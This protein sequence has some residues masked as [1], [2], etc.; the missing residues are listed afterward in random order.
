VYSANEER[1]VIAV[2][3]TTVATATTATTTSA[4]SA[5][6]AS[7]VAAS[8]LAALGV[9]V[10]LLL[11]GLLVT[12]ELSAASDHPRA[13]RLSRLVN[14]AIAPLAMAFVVIIGSR[15]WAILA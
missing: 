3:T 2:T 1:C 14:V 12:K 10:V 11:I 15:V 4:T 9:V 6:A 8:G 7:A 13:Q 5:T